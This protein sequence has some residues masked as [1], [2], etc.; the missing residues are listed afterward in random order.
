MPTGDQLIVFGI[1]AGAL[2]LFIWDRLRYDLVAMLAL[3]AAVVLGVVPG[4]KAFSGFSDTAVVTVAA[5]LVLSTAIR[6]SGLVD[7]ALRPLGPLLR[8]PD[9]QVLI[10]AGMVATLS[11]F[12]NNVGALAV[13]L[14]VA[15][16]VAQRSG[17]SPAELL[18]PLSFA[19]LLGGLITLVGTPPN[20]LISGVRRDML[21]EG[22]AM[23]DFAPVGLGVTAAGLLIVAV[24]WRLLPRHRRGQGD[25][26][27]KFRIEDYTMEVRLPEGSPF[28]GRTV[29]QLE[30]EGEGDVTVAAVVREG[31]RRYVPHGHWTLLADD[32]LLLEGDPTIVK[33]VADAAG[34]VLEDDGDDTPPLAA[35]D[36]YGVVEAVVTETS[37]VVGCS[38]AELR[39]RHRYG[40]NL[41]AIGRH[42]RT[43]ITRLK[44]VKLQPGDVI[45]L[46]G[47]LADMP[48]TLAALGCLPLAERNLQLGKPGNRVLPAAVMAAAVLLAALG[49]LPVAVAFVAAVLVLV[50]TRALALREVYG[51]I[52]WPVIVLLGALIPVSNALRDTGGTEVIAGWL[53]LAV[54]G[55]PPVVAL[56]LIM[57]ATMLVTPVLNNAA[58]VLVMAPIGVGLAQHLG[59]NPDPFLMAVAVGASSDFLTPIGHQSNT[60][61][62]GPAG[63]RFSDYWRLGLPLSLTVLAVGVPLIALVWPLTG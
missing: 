22:F 50:L 16:R 37:P 2:A 59:L 44:R 27:D 54:S 52:E 8:G 5:V 35:G 32:I 60:L 7:A 49:L 13:F 21:G 3:V 36:G 1:L 29:R 47:P 23:F 41:L 46:Q 55:V 26:Q 51:S 62:M 30:D 4:E 33:R 58:T 24:G 48:D 9:A 38:P 25:P 53:S 14:P 42:D 57:A 28:V 19:S 63:Y 61:V 12:M 39:L 45:V 31:F 20:I 56:A 34:L 15:L 6:N 40:V 11:A 10:L 17:R 43:A 18:M